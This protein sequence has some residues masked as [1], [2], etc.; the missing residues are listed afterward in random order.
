MAAGNGNSQNKAQPNTGRRITNAH[1]VLS[2]SIILFRT[3][4]ER[5]K[6]LR[7][8][9][10]LT[11]SQNKDNKPQSIILPHNTISSTYLLQLLKRILKVFQ[12]GF[13]GHPIIGSAE[14]FRLLGVRGISGNQGK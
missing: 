4:A 8:C 6:S 14:T 2:P 11:S 9:A 7:T 10:L 12:A 5:L 13:E 3:D 1:N